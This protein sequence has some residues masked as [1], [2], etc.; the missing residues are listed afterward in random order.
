M[1]PCGS[2]LSGVH[3]MG[4]EERT[5]EFA[6]ATGKAS[7]TAWIAGLPHDE[8]PNVEDYHE[9]AGYP[10]QLQGWIVQASRYAR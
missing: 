5:T 6:S 10:S 2:G 1:G 4:V 3:E 8:L 7:L 9:S